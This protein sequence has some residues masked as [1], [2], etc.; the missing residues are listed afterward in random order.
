M[1][2]V[3]FTRLGLET[4]VERAELVRNRAGGG[5]HPRSPLALVCAALVA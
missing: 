1:I 3:A 5:H 4:R 2:A